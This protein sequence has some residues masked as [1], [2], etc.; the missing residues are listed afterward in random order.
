[1]RDYD[2]LQNINKH[3]IKQDDEV[4]KYIILNFFFEISKQFGTRHF[5]IYAKSML[6]RQVLITSL[7]VKLNAI[8]LRTIKIEIRNAIWISIEKES[9]SYNKFKQSN[10]HSNYAITLK[11]RNIALRVVFRFHRY[12]GPTVRLKNLQ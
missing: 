12:R 1:M 8:L 10:K 4:N 3:Y 2:L 5:L 11:T 7:I 9:L 6:T